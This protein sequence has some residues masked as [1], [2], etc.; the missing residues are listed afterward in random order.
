[1]DK[2]GIPRNRNR[3]KKGTFEATTLISAN[4]AKEAE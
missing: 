4:K 3:E 2:T 1:V